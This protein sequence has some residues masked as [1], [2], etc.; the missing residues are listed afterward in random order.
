MHTAAC[1]L[2]FAAVVSNLGE[3]AAPTPPSGGLFHVRGGLLARQ[4][5]RIWVSWQDGERFRF[6]LELPAAIADSS[7]EARDECE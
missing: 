4:G 3:P 2:G 7:P 5:G 1:V 6:A